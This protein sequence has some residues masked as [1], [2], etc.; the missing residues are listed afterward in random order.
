MV[1]GIIYLN[2]QFSFER[3]DLDCEHELLVVIYKSLFSV[4]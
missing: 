2:T 3:I 4:S 1:T